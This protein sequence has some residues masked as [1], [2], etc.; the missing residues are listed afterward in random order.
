MS[1]YTN[2]VHSCVVDENALTVGVL[3]NLCLPILNPFRKQRYSPKDLCPSACPLEV[4]INT[5]LYQTK[6]FL[7]SD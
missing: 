2:P 1:S 6:H 5:H 3:L 7:F 4:F